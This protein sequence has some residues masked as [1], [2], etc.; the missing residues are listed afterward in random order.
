MK[1]VWWEHHV[2]TSVPELWLILLVE[3]EYIT[4]SDEAESGE[5]HVGTEEP[6]EEACVIKRPLL[7]THKS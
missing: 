2:V 6:Y 3:S 4:R 7:D 5:D 1:E